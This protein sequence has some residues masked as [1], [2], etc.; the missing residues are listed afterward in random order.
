MSNKLPL[1]LNILP[2]IQR[3]LNWVINIK[4]VG[5]PI[6]GRGVK[7]VSAGTV[8][9]EETSH[10]A[11]DKIFSTQLIPNLGSSGTSGRY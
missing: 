6:T 4:N 3:A 9:H 8:H 10:C 11:R 5:T 7:K 1:F 2:W